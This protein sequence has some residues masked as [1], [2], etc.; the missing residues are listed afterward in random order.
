MKFNFF[1]RDVESSCSED[2][3]EEDDEQSQSPTANVPE[4]LPISVKGK[5]KF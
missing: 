4:N 2:T 1:I 3:E 5:E